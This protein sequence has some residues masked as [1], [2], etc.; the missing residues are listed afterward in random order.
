MNATAHHIDLC[1]AHLGQARFAQVFCDFVE[2]LEI[3]QIMVFS[4]EAQGASCLLS[5]HFREGA[6]ADVLAAQYLDGWYKQDPLLPKLLAA[7]PDTITLC[8]FE[9]IQSGMSD[10]YRQ[11]FFDA[12][13]LYAKTT[14]IG[15][16]RDLR[17]FISL[18]QG[19][20]TAVQPDP[21]LA[22]LVG[23]LALLHFD[24]LRQ[25]DHP[26]LLD[27]LSLRERAVCSGMLAGQ[28]AEEIA[29]QIGVAPSTVVT[30][31]KRAYGKLGISSRASLFA[32]C[33]AGDPAV[34]TEE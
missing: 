22:R 30:Y 33:R 15:V 8:T 17:L 4:I 9:Q 23:R 10:A 14:L 27:V 1:L 34:S 24:Q 19:D 6:L 21:A 31:R 26:A 28:K 3:D 29:A 5:R 32:L 2:T 13:G 11:I 12:P 20:L 16:R 25:S 18:Y 7:E